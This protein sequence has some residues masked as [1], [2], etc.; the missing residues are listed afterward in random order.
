MKFLKFIPIIFIFLG[1][2]P[3][4]NFVFADSEDSS[5]YKVLSNTNKKLSI[6]NVLDFSAKFCPG[7]DS[8]WG[9]RG[10]P[11]LDNEILW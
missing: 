10:A 7:G 1:L 2:F 11:P 9:L 8:P 6:K 5:S 4:T 3:Y